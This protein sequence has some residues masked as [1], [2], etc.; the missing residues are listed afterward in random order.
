MGFLNEIGFTARV[1]CS[2]DEDNLSDSRD[3]QEDAHS[4]T[5]FMNE[6]WCDLSHPES[7]FGGGDS[8][9]SGLLRTTRVRNY[10]KQGIT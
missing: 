1:A 7:S 9:G 6:E 3:D 5:P 4:L 2:N 8:L 10:R